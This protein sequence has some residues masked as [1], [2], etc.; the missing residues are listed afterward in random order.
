MCGTRRCE[1]SKAK[2]LLRIP[3]AAKRRE[4]HLLQKNED[5]VLKSV[6]LIMTIIIII[7]AIAVIRL[8]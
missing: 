1:N 3:F 2:P 8:T 4:V 6:I 5:E 7:T